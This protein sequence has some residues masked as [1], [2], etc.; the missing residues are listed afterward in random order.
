LEGK[1]KAA[2]GY[3]ML[4]K[5]DKVKILESP[6]VYSKATHIVEKV[7]LEPGAAVPGKR[8]PKGPAPDTAE[9]G[10]QWDAVVVRSDGR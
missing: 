9:E 8:L 7:I 1:K 3:A 5:G 6:G 10:G 4:V 2:K